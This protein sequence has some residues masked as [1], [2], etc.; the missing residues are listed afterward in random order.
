ML[1]L[2]HAQ[3]PTNI[4]LQTHQWKNKRILKMRGDFCKLSI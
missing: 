3:D 2:P 4:S 1:C